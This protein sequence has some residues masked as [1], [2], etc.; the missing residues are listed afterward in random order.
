MPIKVNDFVIQAKIEDEDVSSDSADSPSSG[1]Q[2]KILK[3]EIMDE[4]MDLIEKY[5]RKKEGR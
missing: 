4:C 5:L 3:A 1:D 2:M